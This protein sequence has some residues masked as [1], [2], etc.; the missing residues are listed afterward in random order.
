[1]IP[2]LGRTRRASILPRHGALCP[3]RPFLAPPGCCFARNRPRVTRP[4]RQVGPGCNISAGTMDCSTPRTGRSTSQPG[5]SG[6]VVKTGHVKQTVPMPATVPAAVSPCHIRKYLII[7]DLITPVIALNRDFFSTLHTM[8]A[9]PAATDAFRREDNRIGFRGRRI[10]IKEPATVT[11]HGHGSVLSE[12]RH[13]N[14]SH[15][16]RAYAHTHI[17]SA[18]GGT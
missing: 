5:A 13:A 18:R 4:S 7:L 8:A 3:G 1:M 15:P 11:S 17:H 10:R 14:P 12:I 16:P 6:R 9:I 2:G